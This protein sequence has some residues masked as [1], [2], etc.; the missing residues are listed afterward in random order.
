MYKLEKRARPSPLFSLCG[1]RSGASSCRSKAAIRNRVSGAQRSLL[2]GLLAGK[3]LGSG[4]E[5][6]WTPQQ[7]MSSRGRS[8][9]TTCGGSPAR[10]RHAGL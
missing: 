8:P 3:G 5:L 2:P 4:P 6:P 1:A 9:K 7:S 10:R